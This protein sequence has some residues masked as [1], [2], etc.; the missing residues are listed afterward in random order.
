MIFGPTKNVEISSVAGDGKEVEAGSFFLLFTQRLYCSCAPKKQRP[1][2]RTLLFD[3][4]WSLKM[5][6]LPFKAVD[7]SQVPS[8]S[9]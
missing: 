5:P 3:R 1:P 2:K 8:S 6:K 9:Q 7:F 4:K